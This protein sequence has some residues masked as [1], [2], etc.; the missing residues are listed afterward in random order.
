MVVAKIVKQLSIDA[1][2]GKCATHVGIAHVNNILTLNNIYCN[3]SADVSYNCHSCRHEV[4]QVLLF[5]FISF[6]NRIAEKVF[7]P[8]RQRKGLPSAQKKSNQTA[9]AER[10]PSWPKEHDWKSCVVK[11]TEGSNPFLSAILF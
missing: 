1:A 4:Q 8:V 7:Y 2:C 6:Y 10:C 9:A 11:A 5:C 3:I